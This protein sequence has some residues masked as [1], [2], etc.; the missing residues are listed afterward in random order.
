MANGEIHIQLAVNYG[1]DP[2]LRSLAKFG[3]D[4][5]GCR[6]LYVQMVCY[7]KSNLTDGIV[8]AEEIGVL[9]YPDSAKIGKRD[10]DRLVEVG[11]LELTPDGYLVRA[12][13][14]RNKSK[15]EV[16]A[17]SEAKSAAGKQGGLRSGQS[18]RR[19]ANPKQSASPDPKQNGPAAEANGKHSASVRLNTEAIGHRPET[20]LPPTAGA[21]DGAE[22][23]TTQRSKRLTDAYA[24]AEPM[25]KWPA[26]NGVVIKAINSN[27]FSD[28]EIRDAL[29]RMA[30]ENR[31]VTVDS[32]RTELGGMPPRGKAGGNGHQ[33][34]A[35]P[36]DAA[37]YDRKY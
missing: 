6:D 16:E 12:F 23:T 30:K 21:E 20:D 24:E 17:I 19:E 31:S 27:R 13:L 9:V 25:C 33:S 34:Y 35:N 3:R 5:R 2:K 22:L 11:V 8:P 15:A 4:A 32:L 37:A 26:V 1:A 14:K 7:S 18:R 29:L 10:A 36:E 28:D